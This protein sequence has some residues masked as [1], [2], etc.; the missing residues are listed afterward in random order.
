M[1]SG[2]VAVTLVDLAFD[3]AA[4]LE[5]VRSCEFILDDLVRFV[6]LWGTINLLYGNWVAAA[7]AGAFCVGLF[8]TDRY[9]LKLVR[10]ALLSAGRR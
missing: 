5:R 1:L 7:V 2:T 3:R 8:R 9:D 6:L 10:T 4:L